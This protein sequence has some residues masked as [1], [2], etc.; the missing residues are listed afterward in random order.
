MTIFDGC[1]TKDL[2]IYPLAKPS[3]E[4]ENHLWYDFEPEEVDTRPLLIVGKALH[5]KNET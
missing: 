1:T 2:I 5:F 4:C 3:S